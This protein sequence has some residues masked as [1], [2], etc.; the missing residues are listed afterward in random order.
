MR[1]ADVAERLEAELEPV[2]LRLVAAEQ[3][4]RPVG[5]RGSRREAVDVDGVREDL[6]RPRGLAEEEVGRALRERALVDDVVGRLHG[7]AERDVERLRS[8][9]G[10]ARIGNPVLVDDDRRRRRRRASQ[11]S[12][13]RSRGRYVVPR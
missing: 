7:R 6:P 10:P 13:R 2:A 5:R 3:Q 11:R 12:G 4:D 1:V 9:S 8:V